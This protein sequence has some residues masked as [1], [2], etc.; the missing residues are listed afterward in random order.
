MKYCVYG[1]VLGLLMV[2]AC[3]KP[4]EI[5]KSLPGDFDPIESNGFESESFEVDG[6]QSWE[7]PTQDAGPGDGPSESIEVCPDEVVAQ[8]IAEMAKK[9]IVPM[10]GAGGLDMT[11]GDWSGLTLDQAQKPDMLCQATYV[12]DSYA[13]WGPRAELVAFYDSD[14]RKIEHMLIRSGY[15]GLLKAGEFELSLLETPIL[16]N[17]SPLNAQDGSVGD[18]RH[19][20][21]MRALDRAL[22]KAFRPQLA[23]EADSLDCVKSGTCYVLSFG[24]V[25]SMVFMSVGLY[26]SIEPYEFKIAGFEMGLKRPFSISAGEST[27]NGTN[28]T[29]KGTTAAGIPDCTITYGTKYSD[30]SAKCIP[31]SD[32]IKM[33]QVQSAWQN[34]YIYFNVG[35]ASFFFERPGLAKDEILETVPEL[36]DDDV[37]SVVSINADY[38]GNFV[39]PYSPILRNFNALLNYEIMVNMYYGGVM[40]PAEL[41]MLPDAASRLKTPDNPNLPADIKDQYADALRPG[42]VY[43]VFCDETV[44]VED[45]EPDAGPDAGP[46][47]ETITMTCDVSPDSGTAKNALLN[48]VKAEVTATMSAFFAA[49]FPDRAA[50]AMEVL[51]DKMPISVY[52][53]LFLAAIGQYLNNDVELNDS[54]L[55]LKPRASRPD[56]IDGMMHIIDG[57]DRYTVSLLYGGN[58]DR[59]HYMSFQKGV[60]RTEAILMAD[61]EKLNPGETE[62]PNVMTFSHLVDSPRLGLEY[63]SIDKSAANERITIASEKRDIRRAMFNFK[64]SDEETLEA[65]AAYEPESTIAGYFVPMTGPQDRFVPATAYFLGGGTFG[66]WF[67][68]KKTVDKDGKEFYQTTAISSSSF[69]GAV[70]ICYGVG[71]VSLG[72]F[73]DEVID[74]LITSGYFSYCDLSIRYSDNREFITEIIDLG[75]SM[76]YRVADNQITSVMAW[77]QE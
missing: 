34:E 21:N 22:I 26:I 64:F 74:G 6:E 52:V 46:G 36:K 17:G 47:E 57:D 31:D 9:D 68:L 42:G 43:G 55:L 29:V 77:S 32:P 11:G 59:I 67:Y 44:E 30:I 38:E 24:T 12:G 13:Y 48:K 54:Q 37:V 61:A 40:A 7:V 19:P 20:D 62:A 69:M 75:M 60:S 10:K 76:K 33:A 18:P 25:R 39:M 23:D 8:K 4:D 63:D 45:P 1:L 53:R 72:D 15:Q 5:Y 2:S 28:L 27:V 51:S 14:T 70:P 73:A 35:G 3:D 49:N 71:V 65:L 41:G 50:A 58:E 66:A 56:Y 16:K